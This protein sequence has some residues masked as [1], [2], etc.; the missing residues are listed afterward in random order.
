MS[1]SGFTISSSPLIKS[2]SAT[3]TQPSLD[4]F[5]TNL[6]EN[7][8]TLIQVKELMGHSNIR[9][10]MCYIHVANIDLGLESPLDVFMKE[11][12][13]NGKK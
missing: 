3:A 7:G 5:A 10:T 6:I 4:C 13:V 1:T 8:A 11:K 2:N 9:S 12:M